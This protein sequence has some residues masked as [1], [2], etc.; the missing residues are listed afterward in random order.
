[1]AAFSYKALDASGAVSRGIIEG[2]SER[3]V[4]ALLRARQLKPLEVSA[5]RGET[6]LL[7]WRGRRA[8]PLPL[9]TLALL[10]R[11]LATLVSAGVQLDEALAATARQCTDADAK[12]L[13]LQVRGKVVAGQSF[14]ASLAAFPQTFS[15][16]Y[17]A[18]VR[19]GE[20]AGLLGDVLEKIADYLE[21]R[22]QLQHKLQMAMIY[23]C[24]LI[25]V[26]LLVIT[27][28]MVFVL[29]DLNDLF[30]RNGGELPLLT[31][32]LMATSAFVGTW[33]PLLLALLL[34]LPPLLR[35]LLQ[36]PQWQQRWHRVSLRLPLV[37]PLLLTA[38]TARFASTLGLLVASG[39][40]LVEAL[41]IAVGVMNNTQLRN[42]TM[43]ATQSVEE[44]GSLARALDSSGCFPPL[45][46]QMIASGESSGTLDA[47]LQR[48]A[49][50]QERELEQTLNGLLKV[51][52][53]LL[54]LVM[55]V[56][57]GTLVV[58]VLLPI[59]QMNT[60]VGA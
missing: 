4:R 37:G 33:W 24:A 59:M 7:P 3:Q 29:P 10:T 20:Q 17:Q 30:L 48:A 18:L 25:G 44:G 49:R 5:S 34:A 23:P 60:L 9:S 50:T 15:G 51:I 22:Q 16:L 6:L 41:T 57:I 19:A 52:E 43:V 38:E 55:A 2:E 28:L 26:A 54:L 58:A 31:R 56:I 13:L 12:T 40:A 32:I 46:T 8:R 53:P 42:A 1:M 14:T 27:V 47:M 35:L 21:L 39:V 45:L 11:Q 36:Q